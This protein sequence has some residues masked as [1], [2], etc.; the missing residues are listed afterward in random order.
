VAAGLVAAGTV[1]AVGGWLAS[2][3]ATAQPP[4]LLPGVP[5]VLPQP[6]VPP[7]PSLPALPSVP[8]PPSRPAARPLSVAQPAGGYIR[9]FAGGE[10]IRLQ[11]DGDRLSVTVQAGPAGKGVELYLEADYSASKEGAVYGL[12]TAA[13]ATGEGAPAVSHLVGEPFAARVR[14]DGDCLSLKDVRCGSV[15]ADELAW[16]SKLAGGRYAQA[17]PAPARKPAKPG[18]ALPVP[19][20]PL[21]KP[22]LI[23]PLPP[24]EGPRA[25][26]PPLD[27]KRL[28][29]F[30]GGWFPGQ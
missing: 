4:A 2:R 19:P 17:G 24:P 6:S 16:M 1:A 25:A 11:F 13:E 27:N 23:P 30:G 7:A 15:S 18:F 9:E 3:P 20:D 12:I 10:S 22:T 21:P 29:T 5:V 28:F 8:T 26:T 14:V